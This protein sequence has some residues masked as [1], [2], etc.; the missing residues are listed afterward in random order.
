MDETLD[1]LLVSAPVDGVEL[2]FPLSSIELISDGDIDPS[3]A[4][5][6]KAGEVDA[7]SNSR[8]MMM[9]GRRIK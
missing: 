5:C 3:A 8:L 7:V 6:A 1:G 4:F 9:C 2:S